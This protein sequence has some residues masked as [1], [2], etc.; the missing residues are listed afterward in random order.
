MTAVSKKS[1]IITRSRYRRTDLLRQ[2]KCQCASLDCSRLAVSRR[3][4]RL[5]KGGSASPKTMPKGSAEGAILIFAN[6]VC[7]TPRKTP[8]SSRPGQVKALDGVSP[9]PQNRQSLACALQACVIEVLN[10]ACNDAPL[11]TQRHANRVSQL[12]CIVI[13]ILVGIVL[14]LFVRICSRRDHG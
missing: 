12:R 6:C 9:Q 10:F 4:E 14:I 5:I 8:P 3:S 11:N 2:G 13:L 1:R 7:L